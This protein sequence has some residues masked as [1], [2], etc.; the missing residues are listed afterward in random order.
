[1]HPN[2]SA[3]GKLSK[4]PKKTRAAYRRRTKKIKHK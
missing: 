3:F 4:I 2:Q 1:M